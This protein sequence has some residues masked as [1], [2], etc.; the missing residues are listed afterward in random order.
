MVYLLLA[1]MVLS[2]GKKDEK[3]SPESIYNISSKWENQNGETL[4]FP[5][6]KGKV[7]VTAMI[8]TS[9]ETACPRLVAEMKNI[10]QKAGKIDSDN[11]Q[12]VLISIDPE[13]DSQE[14]MKAY[15]SANK[16]DNE[17]RTFIRSNEA[18]TRKLA[19]IMVKYKKISPI[20][21]SH[22]NIISLYSKKGILVY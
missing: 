16:I 13:T 22:S 15:L 8:F 10:V 19:N 7:I 20:E 3:L 4:T 6:F 5:D 11:I 21:F 14:V 12:Y 9:C 2:C 1:L 17:Y 18:D